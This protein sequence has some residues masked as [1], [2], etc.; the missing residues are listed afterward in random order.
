[1]IDQ[2]E[3]SMHE[4]TLYHSYSCRLAMIERKLSENDRDKNRLDKTKRKTRIFWNSMLH[5]A[6]F[7]NFWL[8]LQTH[9]QSDWLPFMATLFVRL[10]LCNLLL[11]SWLWLET[12]KFTLRFKLI[13][14]KDSFRF[15]RCCRQGALSS[16]FIV[17]ENTKLQLGLLWRGLVHFMP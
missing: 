17:L 3:G 9:T 12:T 10:F 1:M 11:G 4:I 14:I 5:L 13:E 8:S 6:F 7:S 16:T 15:I 2:K